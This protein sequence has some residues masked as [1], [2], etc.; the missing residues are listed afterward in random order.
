MDQN[1]DIRDYVLEFFTIIGSDISKVD[2]SVYHVSVPDQYVIFFNKPKL[3]FTFDDNIAAKYGCDLVNVGSNILSTI[4]RIC[5]TMGP[6]SIKKSKRVSNGHIVIRCYFFVNFLSI[7]NWSEILFID[8]DWN[9]LKPVTINTSLED[10]NFSLDMIKN[11]PKKITAVY[12][13]ALNE[14]K[15]K[16]IDFKL[17]FLDDVNTLFQNDFKLLVEK[18]DTQIRELD[19]AINDKAKTLDNATKSSEFRFDTVKK[20]E[21][22]EK[23]KSMVAETLQRKYRV[24]LE[25]KLVA[26][27]IILN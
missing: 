7:N 23:E 10:G 1:E 5:S 20:I 22:I 15:T 8:I 3:V 6:I 24:T 17:K 25:Y 26:C 2:N 11:D 16:C 4:I 13:S 27:E 12:A 14:I 21:S 18:Y 9:T 19:T